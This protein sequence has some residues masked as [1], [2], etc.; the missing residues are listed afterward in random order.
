MG[1]EIMLEINWQMNLPQKEEID[2]AWK[3]IEV[4]NVHIN[5]TGIL[6]FIEIFET[7]FS[8][9]VIFECFEISEQEVFDWFASRNRLGEIGFFEWFLSLECVI[10]PFFP[11]EEDVD[12]SKLL[13]GKTNF[14]WSYSLT[15][16]GEIAMSLFDGVYRK[17]EGT[18]FQAKEIGMKFCNSLFGDRYEEIN[19]YKSRTA[20]N[21]WF[22]DFIVDVSYL[23]IDKRNRLVYLL[24][25]T[26]C[27]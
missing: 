12:P 18:C 7:N 24:C 9:E 20:W 14:Q 11:G 15:L 21:R 4:K 1:C 2:K 23:I 17:F 13:T 10:K 19:V 5:D 22:I 8:G 6:E 16:D 26:D 27:D 25:Y 3:E